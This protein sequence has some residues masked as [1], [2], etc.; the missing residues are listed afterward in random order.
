M[1]RAGYA[2][3]VLAALLIAPALA[4]ESYVFDFIHRG[5]H[6]GD[7]EVDA[8]VRVATQACD[9]AGRQDYAGRRFLACMR[10]K[11]LKF[12]RI[13]RTKEASGGGGDPDFSSNVKLAPGDFIDHDSGLDC[14]NSGGASFCTSPQGTVHYFDPDEGVPCTRTGGAAICSNLLPAN[15]N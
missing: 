10:G 5:P 15:P 9:P 1:K 12:V 2:A 3:F 13:D 8:A 6:K 7:A 4:D 11:G 14:V